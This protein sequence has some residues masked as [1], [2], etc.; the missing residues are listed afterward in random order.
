MKKLFLLFSL[1]FVFFSCNSTST[2]NVSVEENDFSFYQEVDEANPLKGFL[3]FMNN[4]NT[5]DYSMEFFYI[6]LNHLMTGPDTF[7]FTALE[8]KLDTI[9]GR[10]HQVVLRVYLDYPTLISGVPDFFWDNGIDKIYYTQNDQEQYF[11]D[12]TNQKCIDYLISFINAFGKEYN[13]DARI[14]FIFCGL[15]GHWGE[16]HNTYYAEA[17]GYSDSKMPSSSQQYELFKAFS[18]AFSKTYCLVRYPTI[19]SLSDF[20]S[21]GFH[22]DSFT[23]DT[24][25]SS[26]SWYFMTQ[27]TEKKMTERW[28]TAPIGGEFRPENQLP[29]LQ[30]KKYQS[31]YQDYDKCVKLT[32]CSW[33][34]YDAAFYGNRTTE[35]RKTAWT[36]SKKLG[37][38]LTLSSVKSILNENTLDFEIQLENKGCAPFYYNWKP[39][40]LI[41][42][43]G[44]ILKTFTDCIENWELPSILPETKKS[45]SFSLDLTDI[46]S[47]TLAGAAVC[48][49]IPN[50]MEGGISLKLSNKS[51][52]YTK[53]ACVDLYYF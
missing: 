47:E 45:Y 3:P 31:Y 11:P 25:D 49:S 35:E 48:L 36:A 34:L 50:P 39:Q 24:Y 20:P 6:P 29:F 17:N 22:D 40:I 53:E 4:Y 26:K 9:A 7:D 51:L 42:K 37:Y 30:G 38:D 1:T 2:T 43:D 21:I 19:S 5:V 18:T 44:V 32:H 15:I 23:E 41:V 46:A 10:G 13:G 12:Y 16:W 14:G 27:L 8:E 33:L 28:Q 52:N